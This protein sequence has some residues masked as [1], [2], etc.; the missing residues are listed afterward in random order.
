MATFEQEEVDAKM[1][2]VDLMQEVSE[3]LVMG[4][5]SHEDIK[6]ALGLA[7]VPVKGEAKKVREGGGLKDGGR[8]DATKKGSWGRSFTDPNGSPR[9]ARPDGMG[10]G[11]LRQMSKREMSAPKIERP[12]MLNRVAGELRPPEGAGVAEQRIEEFAKPE[13]RNDE[14]GIGR[15]HALELGVVE[16]DR[17][18]DCPE[19]LSGRM[20]APRNVPVGKKEVLGD[21]TD[22]D[23]EI[24]PGAECITKSTVAGTQGGD[25][26]PVGP[27]KRDKILSESAEGP[28]R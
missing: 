25:W 26:S 10:T 16:M 11:G 13:V 12:T 28:E 3:D 8:R 19:I 18:E 23:T 20:D 5:D 6:G 27:N 2:E 21:V 4:F 15:H 1:G 9:V 24:T 17:S 14:E 7:Q 22:V